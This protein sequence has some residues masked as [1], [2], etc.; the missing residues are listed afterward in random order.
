MG[1]RDHFR[2][3]VNRGNESPSSLKPSELSSVEAEVDEITKN[4]ERERLT[5]EGI[6]RFLK[7]PVDV[8]T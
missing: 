7:H 1:I 3:M 8:L 5:R 2:N 6:G 4:L